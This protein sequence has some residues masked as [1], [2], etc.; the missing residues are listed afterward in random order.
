MSFRS[1]RH[2]GKGERGRRGDAYQAA[3]TRLQA[4]LCFSHLLGS[5]R[6]DLCIVPNRT[7]EEKE[8]SGPLW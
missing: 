5:L 3:G 2:R 6:Q 8:A 7:V 4:G 1:L